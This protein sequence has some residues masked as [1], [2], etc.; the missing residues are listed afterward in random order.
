MKGPGDSTDD[1]KTSH[2]GNDVYIGTAGYSYAHWRKGVFYP[3]IGVTQ[4]R[5]LRYYSGAFAAVEINAS[6]HGVPREET[7]L[8]WVKTAK[9]GFIF[10][11]KVPRVITHEKRLERIEKDLKFFLDRLLSTIRASLGPILFQLPPSL[12]KDVRKLEYLSSLIPE[13][14]KVAFEFRHKS[15]YCAEVYD[16]MRK[17]NFGLCENIS[18]DNSKLKTSKSD[19]A[20]TAQTWHYVRCHKRGNQMITNYT[21]QQLAQIADLLVHRKNRSIIQY[22]FFL[23]DHEGNGPRNAKTLVALIKEKNSKKNLVHN[24]KPDPIAHLISSLFAEGSKSSSSTAGKSRFPSAKT[25]KTPRSI[26]SFFSALPEDKT[27]SSLPATKRLKMDDSI[28]SK[29]T[30]DNKAMKKSIVSFFTKK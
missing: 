8:T 1:A 23:N 13:G 5:E 4:T 27:S 25:R 24:W 9:P 12:H 18:P 6:F 3:S 14:I 21:D 11:F 15:W 28:S 20:T 7:L 17:M 19:D 22:C 30:F 2:C 26:D 29:T 16:V 10:S